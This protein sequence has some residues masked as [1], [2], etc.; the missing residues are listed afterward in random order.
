MKFLNKFNIINFLVYFYLIFFLFLFSYTFYRAQIIHDGNQI[1]YYLKYYLI[2]GFT[3][4]VWLAVLFF[5]NV[6]IKKITIII[7]S[8]IIFSLYFYETIRYFEKSIL[9]SSLVKKLYK[10]KLHQIND[11][12]KTK[13][14]I[15]E[16]LKLT[17]SINVV[18]SIFPKIFL[19]NK[20]KNEL[21][22]FPLGG[23]S[24]ATTVFCRE[25]KDFSIYKS[26]RFGFNN[27]DNLWD[28]KKINWFLVG[29]SFTQGS[30]VKQEENFSSQIGYITKENS[31]SVG[32]SGNGPLTELAS[33]KEYA[34]FKKPKNILWLY[35]ER[36]DLND[37]K[38]EKF[39]KILIKYLENNFSQ[40]LILKQNQ[41]D[42]I[43]FN[44]IKSAEENLKNN[45][46]NNN[47]NIL[48]FNK[49]IRLKIVRDK[50]ALDRGL[51]FDI[52]PLFEKI[53]INAQNLIK[54]WD[55]KLYF[56]YLPD[57]ERYSSKNTKDETYLKKNHVIEI[58]ENLNIPIIDIHDDFLAKANDPLGFYADRIYGHFSPDGYKKISQ[59]IVSK[60][61]NIE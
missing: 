3:I 13:Y 42:K 58:I 34:L 24:N 17:S 23:V 56:I 32:M 59:F 11:K 1:S 33:L 27:A 43:L 35:F 54:K 9:N 25:G 22:I 61:Q 30:C 10:K 47:N 5:T 39:N 31:I 52:D 49:I 51:I 15:I 41:V 38:K 36:N 45:K 4:I 20:F 55:G 28:K 6:K 46:I 14:E 26:D 57:K 8:S 37:L 40:N 60:I 44:Q 21:K 48:N 53:I 12:Q 2:F 16:E 18:P 29:D 19:E 50:M 7:F